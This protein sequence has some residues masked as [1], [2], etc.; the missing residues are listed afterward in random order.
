MKQHRFNCAQ[1]ENLDFSV[2]LALSGYEQVSVKNSFSWL[3]KF[4]RLYLESSPCRNN[5]TA[6]YNLAG[7]PSVQIF[8]GCLRT[9]LS[10]NRHNFPNPEGQDGTYRA[11]SGTKVTQRFELSGNAVNNDWMIEW[12]PL[13]SHFSLKIRLGRLDLSK[14]YYF[15]RRVF[16]VDRK[17]STTK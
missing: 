17:S 14:I 5:R 2:P 10:P 8:G 3:Y 13:S 11:I 7:K 1:N 15:L 12:N 16:A 9:F 6:P 4:E